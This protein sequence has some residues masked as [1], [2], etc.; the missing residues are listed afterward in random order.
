[1]KKLSFID[2]CLYLVNSVLATILFIGYIV[3]YIAPKTF[4]LLSVFSVVT[5]IFILLNILFCGYWIL[6]LKKQFMVS[7]I[8]LLLGLQHCIALYQFGAKNEATPNEVSLLSYNVRLFNIYQW[9][10][11]K[12]I[13]Q[14]LKTYINTQSVDIVCLQEY[15]KNTRKINSYKYQ[16]IRHNG[17]TIGQ[18]ILSNHKFVNKGNLNFSNSSNNSIFADIK[19]NNDTIRVYNIHLESLKIDKNKEV[20]D[21][22]D[23]EKLVTKFT[24]RFKK[25]MT[26]VEQIIAHEATSPYKTIIAGDF[27]N[28]AFSWIYKTLKNNKKDAFVEAGSGFGKT[29]DFIFPYR[30]D[31]IL[32]D[33]TFKVNTYESSTV[34][35][36]DHF[37]IVTRFEIPKK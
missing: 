31:F 26:Q 35:Y 6:R 12:D 36:S 4:A 18:A 13:E 11:E 8:V 28:T 2:T 23:P 25:Q 22:I 7:A 19:I 24:Y 15:H 37:P 1:M 14:K 33:D 16:Y 5:P 30:I 10:K 29:F 17:G 3:P 34:A 21:A 27:N 9:T 32:L 20:L